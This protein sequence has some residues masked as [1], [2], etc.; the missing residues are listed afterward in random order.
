MSQGED[1]LI[2]EG[3]DDICAPLLGEADPH[4]GRKSVR[5]RDDMAAHD[6]GELLNH[7]IKAG[8]QFSIDKAWLHQ[9][10]TAFADGR[11]R[12]A[13]MGCE[14]SDLCSTISANGYAEVRIRPPA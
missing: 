9:M 13:C 4:C 7:S 3:P 10:S 11:T 8:S 12:H 6:V 2:V 1:I 5:E 14:W